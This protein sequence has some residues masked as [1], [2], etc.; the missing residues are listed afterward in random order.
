MLRSLARRHACQHGWPGALGLASRRCREPGVRGVPLPSAPAPPGCAAQPTARERG[1]GC[2]HHV[3]STGEPAGLRGWGCGTGDWHV[4]LPDS[5]WPAPFTRRRRRQTS[6]PYYFS[7]VD[8]T[9]RLYEF[10]VNATAGLVVKRIELGVMRLA[11]A[12]APRAQPRAFERERPRF[13]LCAHANI[14]WGDEDGRAV[15][16]AHA[17]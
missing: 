13:R 8:A 5:F 9:V 7:A 3:S 6:G 14:G 12:G 11:E 10:S 4:S 17:G 15:V 2:M 16:A 1:G